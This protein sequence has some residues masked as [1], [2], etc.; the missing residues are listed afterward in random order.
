MDGFAV[1]A[2][3]TFGAGR[4]DRK[5]SGRSRRCTRADADA[6]GS[7]GECIEI[8]TGAPMP[9]GA[10]AVVMV[11]ETEKARR[12][13]PRRRRSTR[14]RTSAAAAPIIS[15]GADR[16]A[17]GDVLTASRVGALAA[18]GPRRS[19]STPPLGRDPFDRQRDHRAGPVRSDRRRS[20]TSTG[21]RF[22][23]R[24]SARRRAQWRCRPRRT[25]ST[26]ST[27]AVERRHPRRSSCSRAAVRSANGT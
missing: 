27:A 9:D 11:E 17:A 22:G 16:P 4:F 8:A 3:D 7:A 2:E 10:N 25:R 24:R 26:N 1:I 20:T 15:T 18:L 12:P 14:A 19:R 23:D 13:D 5:C 21:S 6:Q